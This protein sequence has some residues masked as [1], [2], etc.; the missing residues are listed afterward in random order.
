MEYSTGEKDALIQMIKDGNKGTGG[1]QKVLKKFYG[2]L[3]QHNRIGHI[4]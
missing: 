2:R 1:C 4:C 3:L